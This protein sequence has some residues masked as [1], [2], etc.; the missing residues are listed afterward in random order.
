MKVA[1]PLMTKFETIASGKSLRNK[2]G[3]FA[4]TVKIHPVSLLGDPSVPQS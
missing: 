4:V 2:A 3:P 1:P